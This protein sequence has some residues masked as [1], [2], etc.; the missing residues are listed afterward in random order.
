MPSVADVAAFLDALAPPRLAA[1]WDNVGLLVGDR[2]RDVARLMTCLTVTP[3]SVAEAI[4]ERVGLIVTHH[5]FP[6]RAARRITSDTVEG[7]MLLALV[8]AGVAVYS[9]H[10]A[11]DSAVGGINERLGQALELS[12]LAPLA[13][14]AEVPAAGTGRWGIAGGVRLA[15]IAR[16]CAAFLQRDGV[17]IVGDPQQPIQ[18]LGIA[19]GSGGEL[20][21]AARQAGCDGFLTGET[22]FHTCL[23][24]QAAGVALIL[25]GHYASERFAVEA[26]AGILGKQ[27][28]PIRCWASRREADP[29][30][31]L[32]RDSSDSIDEL[33]DER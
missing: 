30:R 27:F 1:E 13:A 14:D 31:W 26:L 19:C 22:R 2:Q 18:R 11:F 12:D 6:F 21:D 17:Q 29:L 20:L 25:T 32:A 3:D 10:T 4:D 24:A 33:H 5:P 8:S 15:E 7:R 9:A 16:R 28:P 23:E